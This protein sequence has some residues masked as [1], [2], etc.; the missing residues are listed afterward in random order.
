MKGIG[1]R[2]YKINFQFKKKAREFAFPVLRTGLQ[3]VKLI[4]TMLKSKRISKNIKT[5]RDVRYSLR[6]KYFSENAVL[7]PIF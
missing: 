2:V 5:F 1:N 7:S 6:E 3:L 4:S